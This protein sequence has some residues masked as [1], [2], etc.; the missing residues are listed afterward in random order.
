MRARRRI[1]K[2]PLEKAVFFI[3]RC[4]GKNSVAT[5]LRDGGLTIELHDDHFSQD[6]PDQEWLPAIGV[7]RWYVI[8]RDE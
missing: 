3:D 7:R 2:D 5:P 1:E 4:V 8:T 6:A